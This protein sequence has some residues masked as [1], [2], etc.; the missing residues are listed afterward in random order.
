[1]N[2]APPPPFD[3]F[4]HPINLNVG[5]IKGGDWPSTVPAYASRE[6]RIALYPGVHDRR[7]RDADRSDRRRGDRRPARL[8]RGALRRLRVRGLRHR[9]RPST[10]QRRWRR[11]SRASRARRPRWCQPPGPRTP[12]S[13]ATWRA[14]RRCASGPTRSRRTGSMNGCTFRPWSRRLRCWGCSSAIGAG[15]RDRRARPA[16]RGCRDRGA[17]DLGVP[18]S[19]RTCPSPRRPPHPKTSPP[20]CRSWRPLRRSAAS[21][22]S[23]TSSGRTRR[24]STSYRRPRSTCSGSIAGCATSGSS[25]T[26]TR[27]TA[28]TRTSSSR[29]S[30]TPREFASIE[31]ICN[32]LLGHKEVVDYVGRADPAARSRS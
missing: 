9:G 22:P 23:G 12:P 26:T 8:R 4:P 7:A 32:Y 14:S 27:S 13:S 1:M 28:G 24:R 10:G 31:E 5:T 30:S 20:P 19:R 11:R 16:R 29:T 3:L 6:Y 21:P 2:V 25:T 18:R 17:R 15:C